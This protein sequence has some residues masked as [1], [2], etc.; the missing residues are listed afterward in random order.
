MMQTIWSLS[1]ILSPGVAAVLITLPALARQGTIRGRRPWPGCRNGAALAMMI[2]AVTFLLASATLLFLF[3]PSPKRTDLVGADGQM[4]KSLW[5][6][7]KEGGLYIWHRRPLLWLLGT[8]TVA[9]FVG[10]PMGVFQPLLVKFNLAADWTARGFQF[11]TALALLGTVA[12]IGGVVGGL[13][14]TAWGGLKRRRV[15][16]VVVPL[17]IS[18]IGAG[19]LRP[20]GW[21]YLSAA[22]VFLVRWHDPDH[23]LALADHLADADAARA[24]GPGLLGASGDRPVHL[25]AQH[26]AG[27]LGRW[28]LRSGRG[29]GRVGR[30]PG[31]L[32]HRPALQPTLDAG[33]R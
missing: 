3:I 10:S 18:G 11:E 14:I 20:V 27:R 19:R 28:P 15:F 7:V 25:A 16:G 12:A 33:R 31:H 9:N 5:A 24:A 13:F 6:D 32:L 29:R 17:I 21:L 2:D 8:F 4:K 30:D 26:R 22:M 23:E 1:G